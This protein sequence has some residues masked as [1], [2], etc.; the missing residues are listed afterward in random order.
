MSETPSM[1]GSESDGNSVTAKNLVTLLKSA[2][3]FFRNPLG[4]NFVVLEGQAFTPSVK[5]LAAIK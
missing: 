4:E 5:N 1:V 3:C 2:A